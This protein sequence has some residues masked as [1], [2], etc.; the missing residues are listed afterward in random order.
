MVH[1]E[2]H[3]NTLRTTTGLPLFSFSSRN[4]AYLLLSFRL[5]FFEN[6][7]LDRAQPLCLSETP[8]SSILKGNLIFFSGTT[9]LSKGKLFILHSIVQL[10]SHSN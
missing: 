1:F 9:E 2:M 5:N 7:L 4:V 10:F 8:L 6:T 3:Q